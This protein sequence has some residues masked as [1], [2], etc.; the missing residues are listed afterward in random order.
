MSRRKRIYAIAIL[1]RYG[2]THGI[3]AWARCRVWCEQHGATMVAP[4]WLKL[5]IGPYLRREFDKRNYFL[6]FHPGRGVA[7]LKR[8]AL[9]LGAK[10]ID[11]RTEWPEI[12]IAGNGPT[13][14]RF[15]NENTNNEQSFYQIAEHGDFLRRELIA[16]T[17]PRYLPAEVETP[18]IALHVRMGDFI[19]PQSAT[20]TN[21]VNTRLPVE[22]YADRLDALRAALGMPLRAVV[23]SDGD[24]ASLAPLLEREAV[25]RAPRQQSVTDLLQIGQGVAL[26]ASRSG[27]SLWGAFLGNTPRI[28]YPGQKIVPIHAHPERDI[29]SA[30]GTDI[31]SSFVD[32]IRPRIGG[33]A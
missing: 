9:V 13:L 15:H 27:F 31:P 33:G 26:I 3:L 24:D 19:L 29:E 2:L 21:A 17:R 28:S 25:S 20:I 30:I 12:D 5:R 7:G 23:F 11:V 8:L 18:F 14:I 22:W 1:G 4:F 16:I 6:L 32:Q 10:R